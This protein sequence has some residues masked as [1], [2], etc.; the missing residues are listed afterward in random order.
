MLVSSVDPFTTSTVVP[1]I[2]TPTVLAHLSFVLLL[3]TPLVILSRINSHCLLVLHWLFFSY[4]HQAHSLHEQILRILLWNAT[5]IHT[6]DR[7]VHS[8]HSCIAAIGEAKYP[9]DQYV[10]QTNHL[11][12]SSVHVGVIDVMIFAL[13]RAYLSI[14]G[15][16]FGPSM[17]SILFELIL[18]LQTLLYC[19]TATVAVHAV[20]NSCCLCN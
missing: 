12:Y 7:S 5:K 9:T 18:L 16:T 11:Q 20:A 8:M 3:L 14:L 10:S 19:M 1:S 6:V 2:D 13:S 17:L 4:Y 15:A